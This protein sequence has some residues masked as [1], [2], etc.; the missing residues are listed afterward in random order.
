MPQL[1][2][3]LGVEREVVRGDAE[4]LAPQPQPELAGEPSR[5]VAQPAGIGRLAVVGFG[6]HHRARQL[7]VVRPR[8]QA[9]VVRADDGPHVVD[10]A[11]L[12]VHVDRRALSV[13]R[14]VHRDPV[15]GGPL[16]E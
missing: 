13:H 2:P 9:H 10:D 7:R 16:Q 5:A 15:P 8:P 6:V 11:D 3:G 1:D 12:R 14:L 4:V